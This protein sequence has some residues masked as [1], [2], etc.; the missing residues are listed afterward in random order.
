[1]RTLVRN[2]GVNAMLYCHFLLS[3]DRQHS[4]PINSRC[5]RGAVEPLLSQHKV[6]TQRL[7]GP[8]LRL[9]EI[10]E[11]CTTI[12]GGM[13]SRAHMKNRLALL[14]LLVFTLTACASPATKITRSW[15]SPDKNTE[16]YKR[17]F[18]AAVVGDVTKRQAIETN[19][20]AELRKLN[21]ASTTSASTIKPNFWQS[22]DLDKEAMLDVVRKSEKDA[23]ITVS[24]VDVKQEQ[25]YI[26]GNMMGGGPMMRGAMMGP[27]IGPGAWARGANFG[28]FWG[29]NH[30]MMM[31]PGHVVND[32]RYFMEINVYDTESELLVWSAQSE[33]LNPRSVETFSAEFSRIV[34]QRMR[35][36]GVLDT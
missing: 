36:D 1:M 7:L 16:G 17:L 8:T 22:T 10:D 29:W 35:S 26:P 32:Q 5:N 6:A 19:I 9:F 18:V 21:L 11:N 25:R 27:G 31:T 4:L 28:G 3:M 2:S 13:K 14:A 12:T 15:S 33:T 34:I 24:L 30:G 23:I 20:D